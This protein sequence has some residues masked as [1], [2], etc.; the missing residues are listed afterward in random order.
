LL[1]GKERSAGDHSA[2]DSDLKSPKGEEVVAEAEKIL[3]KF[4]RRAYRRAV[5]SEDLETPL[6]FFKTE[7][8]AD[9]FEAGIESA[10]SAVL[11]N[12]NF[13]FRI[14]SERDVNESG[15]GGK[16]KAVPARMTPISDFELASRLSYFL[17]SSCPDEELL[18]L[19]EKNQ[20]GQDE[21]LVAQVKRMLADEKSKSLTYNFAAQWLYLRNLESVTPDLRLFPDF[22]DNLRQSFRGE[23]ERLF[24]DVV[25]NDR[26]VLGLIKSSYTFLNQRLAKHYGVPHVSGSHFRRVDLDPETKAG[27]R[28]GGI[29]RHGSVLM[30]TSY[31]TR[32]S[33]TIRGNWILE[34][35]IGSPAPPPPPNIPNLKENT[36]LDITSVRE[37]LAQHRKDPACASC[38]DL[39]DPVG[40]SLENYDAIGRWRDFE[41]TLDVD[42]DG[43]LP[44]GT[45][46]GSVVELERGILERPEMFARTLTGKLMTFAIGRAMNA[47]D[48][49]VVRRIAAASADDDFRF[50][51][52]VKGVVLSKP[53]RMRS[54][55]VSSEGK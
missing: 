23:T 12:P 34:N 52:I 9:G 39:I 16:A 3:A 31:A 2:G 50:S 45:E 55:I 33:P 15:Q 6:E 36:T 19:A 40:F 22:D 1:L 43:V 11:V 28:R 32:T 37:R 29:L 53:F 44:D 20:L 17:W 35:L 4:I 48:G 49:P 25:R 54:N 14:E 51:S 46:I 8:E 10:V 42:S 30:V 47:D 24:E 41:E 38:H 27:K 21:V 26:S 13:L 18:G 5:T 7:S